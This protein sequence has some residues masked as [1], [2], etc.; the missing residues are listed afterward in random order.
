MSTAHIVEAGY[1][2]LEPLID[3]LE[4]PHWLRTDSDDFLTFATPIIG[5]SGVLIAH[6][7]ASYFAAGDTWVQFELG[8]LGASFGLSARNGGTLLRAIERIHRFGYGQLD[9][10]TP[11]LRVRTAIPPLPR[12]HAERIPTY[13]LDHCPYVVR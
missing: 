11:T 9:L 12:R 1:L 7:A 5:P 4:E 3:P 8:D 2:I 6:R 10:R 13:L